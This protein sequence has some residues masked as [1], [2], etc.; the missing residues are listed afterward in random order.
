MSA[1]NLTLKTAADE[2]GS[3]SAKKCAVWFF[4]PLLRG[5]AAAPYKQS[6]RHLKQG[7]AGEVRLN[8]TIRTDLPSRADVEGSVIFVDRRA[9]TSSKE[10]IRSSRRWTVPH[11]TDAVFAVHYLFV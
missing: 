1:E 8:R 4:Y 5:G 7:A 6:S 10:G 11:L 3:E 9:A 2:G